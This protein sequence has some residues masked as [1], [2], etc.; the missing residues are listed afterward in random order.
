MSNPKEQ[1]K[2]NPY[3]CFFSKG[4]GCIGTVHDQCKNCNKRA[5]F[6]QQQLKD[7]RNGK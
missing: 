7:E 4:L 3:G 1:S 2:E 6:I 5:K